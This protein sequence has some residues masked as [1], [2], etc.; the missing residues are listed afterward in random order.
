M[1]V[2]SATLLR[3]E[4]LLKVGL[5][6]ENEELPKVEDCVVDSLVVD[7]CVNVVEAVVVVVGGRVGGGGGGA[8]VGMKGKGGDRLLSI[9]SVSTKDLKFC[10]D[11]SFC[12]LIRV[13]ASLLGLAPPSPEVA[14]PPGLLMVGTADKGMKLLSS[15]SSRTCKG[16]FFL[17]VKTVLVLISHI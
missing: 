12:R 3:V 8:R 11:L 10:F 17:E 4:V 13:M 5:K 15:E 2:E 1:V 16:K 9:K 7:D 14:S 6:S